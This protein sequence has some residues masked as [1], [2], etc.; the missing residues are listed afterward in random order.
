MRRGED[1]DKPFNRPVP[2][3]LR[4]GHFR[5]I[6]SVQEAAQALLYKWPD[7]GAGKRHLAA[8]RACLK[9]LE[10]LAEAVAAR[11]AFEAAARESGNLTE[12]PRTITDFLPQ[13]PKPP[14]RKPRNGR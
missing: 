7:D 5:S 1:L 4:D 6:E 3:R 8:R 12:R 2:I 10:G 11:E 13:P 9:V 14:A